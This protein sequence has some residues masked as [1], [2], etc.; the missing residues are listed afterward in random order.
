MQFSLDKRSRSMR[1]RRWLDTYHHLLG[2]HELLSP[3]ASCQCGGMM[4]LH[5]KTFAYSLRLFFQH[6]LHFSMLY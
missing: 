3:L 4:L 5:F 6:T 1:I 2:S